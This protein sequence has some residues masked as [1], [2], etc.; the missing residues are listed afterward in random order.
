MAFTQLLLHLIWST[1]QRAPWLRPDIRP[2]LFAYTSGICRNINAPLVI[3]G[4]VEDHAH[5]LIDLH[6]TLAPADV[7][8]DIKSNSSRFIHETWPELAAFHWQESYSAFAVSYSARDDVYRYIENQPEH[9]RTRTFADELRDF[10]VKHD[11]AWDPE[12]ALR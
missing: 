11:R 5:F 1:R 12:S 8:R 3:A 7:V 4:G 6:P 9:H 10:Y 2:R